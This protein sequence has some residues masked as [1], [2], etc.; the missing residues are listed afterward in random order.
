MPN[1]DDVLVLGGLGFLLWGVAL[2]YPPAALI[3]LGLLM[4]YTGYRRIIR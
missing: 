4:M 3:L 1:V 2:V